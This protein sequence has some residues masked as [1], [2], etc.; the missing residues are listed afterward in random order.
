MYLEQ[1]EGKRQNIIKTNSRIGST[2]F[3]FFMKKEVS[4]PYYPAKKSGRLKFLA[5]LLAPSAEFFSSTSIPLQPSAFSWV[6]VRDEGPQQVCKRQVPFCLRT[7]P[8]S[9]PLRLHHQGGKRLLP[10]PCASWRVHKGQRPSRRRPPQPAVA[11]AAVTYLRLRFADPH[12][13]PK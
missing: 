13:Q 1:A 9:W 8:L 4:L 6:V 3:P 10:P 7:K 2:F 12:R 11:A 5:R